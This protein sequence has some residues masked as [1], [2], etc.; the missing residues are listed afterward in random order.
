MSIVIK[1][2]LYIEANKNMDLRV[3]LARNISQSQ[4]KLNKESLSFDF[5]SLN[6]DSIALFTATL[7]P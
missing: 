7:T 2:M 4:Y 5:L 3:I 1:L 6:L